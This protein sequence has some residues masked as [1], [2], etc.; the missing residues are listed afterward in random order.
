MRILQLTDLYPPVIGGTERHT[1]RLAIALAARGHVS[2]VATLQLAGVPQYEIGAAGER[3]FRLSS[4]YSRIP[5]AHA[6][7][8]PYHPPFPDPVVQR[9]LRTLI[10][11]ERP[12]VIY[13]HNWIVYSYAGLFAEL[14]V[15]LVYVLHDYCMTCPAKTL[16]RSSERDCSHTGRDRLAC[17]IENYG[18]ARGAAIDAGLELFTHRLRG[19]PC[20]YVAISEAVAAASRIGLGADTSI[21]VIPTFIADGLADSVRGRPRPAFLP[22]GDYILFVGALG[23]HKGVQLLLDAYRQLQAPKPELVLLAAQGA[24][25]VPELPDGVILQADV[26]HADVMSAWR[27]CL[28]GVVPSLWPEPFGQVALEALTMGR[29][30]IASDGGGLAEIVRDRDNGLLFTPGAQGELVAAMQRLINDPQLRERLSARAEI[31]VERY[32]VSAVADSVERLLAGVIASAS[33]DG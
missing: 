11:A 8:R 7:H 1:Q 3:V 10:Q 30:V 22:D 16:L 32:A 31:G 21:Q 9:E 24:A 18:L 15:P 33:A 29:P 6:S 12:D 13:A 2:M 14:Q 23:R 25:Q 19:V 5:K 27:D 17:S 4:L 28:F 20:T 26:D